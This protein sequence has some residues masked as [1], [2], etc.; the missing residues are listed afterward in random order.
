VDVI[1]AEVRFERPGP[2][3]TDFVE[4]VGYL[5]GMGYRFF[6]FYDTLYEPWLEYAWGDI[7]M[8][9]PRARERMRGKYT[10]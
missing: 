5:Q 1:M 8:V 6:G 9:S 4:L 7:V 2:G 3:A 10:R